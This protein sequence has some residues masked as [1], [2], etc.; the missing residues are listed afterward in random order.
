MASQPAVAN[1]GLPFPL[2]EGE[3]SA[4][5]DVA[6]D[7]ARAVGKARY[8]AFRRTLMEFVE[9]DR[10]AGTDHRTASD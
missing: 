7:W 2:Q 10:Q 4:A 9:L 3:R 8:E 5:A 1:P 6:S